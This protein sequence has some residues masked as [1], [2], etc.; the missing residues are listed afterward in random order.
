[1]VGSD[2]RFLKQIS[3]S[4]GSL[5]VLVQAPLCGEQALQALTRCA[6]DVVVLDGLAPGL[7]GLET[8]RRIRRQRPG[9]EAVVLAASRSV[10][11]A[12]RA[13]EFG[14]FDYILKPCAPEG[15]AGI[16]RRALEKLRVERPAGESP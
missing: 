15:V 16:I 7:E 10:E 11:T 4:L 6:P 1:M 8:L 2:E 12:M 14:A 13:M 3:E 5:G 9:T